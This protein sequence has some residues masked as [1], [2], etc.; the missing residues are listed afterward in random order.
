MWTL[1]ILLAA[2]FVVAFTAVCIVA[3]RRGQREAAHWR[4]TIAREDALR[5]GK[6]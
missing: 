3:N 2:L 6:A 1:T 5:G 4:A